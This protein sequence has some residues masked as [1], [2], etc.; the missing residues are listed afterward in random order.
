MERFGVVERRSKDNKNSSG[1]CS[2]QWG[3]G[4]VMQ[5]GDRSFSEVNLPQMVDRSK[6]ST[7]KHINCNLM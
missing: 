7:A 5:G 2:C 1:N 3:F 6:T 4:F